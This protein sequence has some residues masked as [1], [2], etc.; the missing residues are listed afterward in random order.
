M[1]WRIPFAMFKQAGRADAV[2]TALMSGLMPAFQATR[3]STNE[4]LKDSARDFASRE[5]DLRAYRERIVAAAMKLPPIT[6]LPRRSAGFLMPDAGLT[7]TKPC[8][9]RRC[10]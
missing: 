6:F 10:R 5:Q 4:L 9:K 7:K 2:L 8:R 3:A 1:I